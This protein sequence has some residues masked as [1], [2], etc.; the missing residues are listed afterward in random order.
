MAWGDGRLCR[1]A[2][3]SVGRVLRWLAARLGISGPAKF[4][5]VSAVAVRRY[6]TLTVCICISCLLGR[7]TR[8]VESPA[9]AEAKLPLGLA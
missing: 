3:H 9:I 8:L 5:G 2:L 6:P 7:R 1:R 4:F